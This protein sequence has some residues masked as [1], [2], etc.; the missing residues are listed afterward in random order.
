VNLP[1]KAAAPG[2]PKIVLVLEIFSAELTSLFSF[3]N[4]S[5]QRH[6]LCPESTFGDFYCLIVGRV[7]FPHAVA[8]RGEDTAPYLE[9]IYGKHNFGR[10]SMGRR[11]QRQNH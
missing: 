8:R 3:P 5:T 11:R 2:K 9:I 10:R 1:T 7:E 4:F 6:A